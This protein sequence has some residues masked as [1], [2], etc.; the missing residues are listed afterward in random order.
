MATFNSGV[1]YTFSS[2]YDNLVSQVQSSTLLSPKQISDCLQALNNIPYSV[3]YDSYPVDDSFSYVGTNGYQCSVSYEF[4]REET[5]AFISLDIN[6]QAP[7]TITPPVTVTLS[8]VILPDGTATVSYGSQVI[9]AT[10]GTSPYTFTSSTLPTGLTLSSGG[11]L[12]GTPT[13]TNTYTFTVSAADSNNVKGTQSY[14]I[15]VLAAPIPPFVP[16]AAPTIPA[17]TAD[18]KSIK[19]IRGISYIDAGTDN[20]FQI[21]GAKFTSTLN[22]PIIVNLKEY[23]GGAIPAGTTVTL[24]S[25]NNVPL[26]SGYSKGGVGETGITL[27]Y[28]P[29]VGSYYAPDDATFTCVV[30]T[31]NNGTGWIPVTTLSS[32]GT[33]RIMQGST[34]AIVFGPDVG[35]LGAGM[36]TFG[37]ADYTYFRTVDFNQIVNSTLTPLQSSSNFIYRLAN[38]GIQNPYNGALIGASNNSFLELGYAQI[39]PATAGTNFGSKIVDTIFSF[40]VNTNTPIQDNPPVKVYTP[41]TFAL[42]N[43]PVWLQVDTNASVD[44]NTIFIDWGSGSIQEYGLLIDE[45]NYYTYS[46]AQ[47]SDTPYTVSLTACKKGNNAVIT[48]ALATTLSSRFYIQD[49]FP[50]IDLQDYSKTLGVNLK[51]PYTKEEIEV[52]SNEWAVA[53]N[54]NASFEKIDTNF[55]YLNTVSKSIKKESAFNCVEWLADLVAY[56][57]W[58]TILSGS[59][60]YNNLSANYIGIVP[61]NI[62]EFKSYKSGNSVPDFYN[63]IVYSSGNIQ[64]RENNLNNNLV[65]VLSSVIP[66][67]TSFEARTVDVSG[68]SLYLL[69][70]NKPA[71]Q[72][73]TGRAASLYRFNL[74]YDSNTVTLVNQ[75]GG[76]TGNRGSEY[77]FGYRPF[78]NAIKAYN[79]KVYVGDTSN[80]CIKVYNSALT[81]ITT[82]YNNVLSAYNVSPFD[83]NLSTE[84]VFLLGKI[85]APNSPVITSVTST[86]SSGAYTGYTQYFVTWNHDGERLYLPFTA[87]ENAANF[88]VYGQ[89]QSI[90]AYTLLDSIYS[91]HSADANPKLTTYVFSTSSTYSNFK[92]Q[93]IGLESGFDSEL[94]S[95]IA[96]PNKNSFPSP[97]AVFE[98]DI[99]GN[100]V[101]KFQIAEVPST[102]TIRKLIIDPTSTFFYVITSDYIYKYTVTGLFVNRINN[103]SKEVGAIGAYEDI[104]TAFIDERSYFYVVTATR[105]F[106][107]IDLPTTT[108][109]FDKN[110]VSSYYSPLS[111]YKIN[112]DE[113]IQD[114]VYNKAL[115]KIYNNH[116]VLAKSIN[117]KYIITNDSNGNLITFDVRELSGAEPINS[118][119]ATEDGFIHSNEIVSSAVVNRCLHGIY[120]AQKAILDLIT[121]DVKIIDPSYTTNIIGRNSAATPNI[122]YQYIQPPPVII[123]QT[124]DQSLLVNSSATFSVTVSSA[125]AN[126]ALNYQWYF[127]DEAVGGA[128]LSAYTI[129]SAQLTDI[130]S[131]YCVASDNAGSVIS[132]PANL[133]VSLGTLFAFASANFVG[134]LYSIYYPTNVNPA[135]TP[136]RTEVSNWLATRYGNDYTATVSVINATAKSKIKLY[137]SESYGVN[138]NTFA[139]NVTVTV[140][141]A[142]EPVHVEQTTTSKTI[143]LPLSSYFTVASPEVAADGYPDTIAGD[144]SI[145][146]SVG[147]VTSTD[148]SVPSLIVDVA[149][150]GYLYNAELV[151]SLYS[152]EDLSTCFI[153]LS[154]LSGNVPYATV[155]NNTL[156]GYLDVGVDPYI[157]HEWSVDGN[158]TTENPV[159]DYTPTSSSSVSLSAARRTDPGETEVVLSM[160][161]KVLAKPAVP[162]YTITTQSA[163][164]AGGGGYLTGGGAAKAGTIKTVNAEGTYIIQPY[165][166]GRN[167]LSPLIISGQ[168]IYDAGNYGAAN[169]LPVNAT[170]Y[171]GNVSGTLTSTRMTIFVD[172]DKTVQ[173]TFHH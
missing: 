155:A 11:T 64:V 152:A 95:N 171:G 53:D 14:T 17:P 126:A 107:F 57:T 97:Y 56:P 77:A 62:Q 79:N 86:V 34:R 69:A 153:L 94:S 166:P 105:I 117:A 103:P 82:I 6:V 148:I 93:A 99:N 109:L 134:N 51:L 12:T 76:T 33:G 24:F 90:G 130:G 115:N 88:R 119:S 7:S 60:T 16:P 121:P 154:A 55:K 71:T 5:Y 122:I 52:G 28:P 30:A 138:P 3:R 128:Q 89:I 133:T 131:Y 38:Q 132:T 45:T 72:T 173:V 100:L 74:D 78:P 136:G 114:W 161:R 50:T 129:E 162:Y 75:I 127:N 35:N 140:S 13:V 106:K 102:A 54:I 168:G 37:N 20:N 92:I 157:R 83:L 18:T 160:G 170:G 139:N 125:S 36:F 2:A 1:Q 84:N 110:F 73:G 159:V 32:T 165:G 46:Y 156:G 120:N 21:L 104:V 49:S 65:L 164:V 40:E 113:L 44:R 142:G 96:V 143:I 48:N 31:D 147:S 144:I 66:G 135:A 116:E 101:N 25:S 169:V 111:S 43:S 150:G 163:S 151:N 141:H 146:L 63:Y 67:I 70:V 68:N 26:V 61:G 124:G 58:N 59:N 112:E 158:E 47:A 98:L 108:E 87:E 137:L 15:K 42:T 4:R 118:L 22:Q 19:A 81:Y 80:S 85:K 41:W 91:V 145:S 123:D 172:G 23:A 27:Y 29:V 9:T 167:S 149:D 39:N 8:P 10:G